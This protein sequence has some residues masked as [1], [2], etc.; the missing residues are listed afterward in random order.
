MFI[1]NTK[2]IIIFGIILQV[3]MTVCITIAAIW[4]SKASVLWFYLIPFFSFLMMLP[5]SKK[6]TE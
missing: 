1:N 2:F 5:D 3:V 6:K 4:F